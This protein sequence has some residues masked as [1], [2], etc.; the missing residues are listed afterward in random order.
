[1]V[2]E[3]RSQATDWRV[4]HPRPVERELAVLWAAAGPVLSTVADCR[5]RA[6]P[7]PADAVPAGALPAA[8]MECQTEMVYLPEAARKLPLPAYQAGALGPDL[9]AA[10]VLALELMEVEARPAM[11]MKAEVLA[12]AMEQEQLRAV[13][14]EAWALRP[15]AA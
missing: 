11:V 13:E 2:A 7:T 8:L 6:R 10:V 12:V 15:Q 5:H 14:R 3:P 4:C 9:A 1:M